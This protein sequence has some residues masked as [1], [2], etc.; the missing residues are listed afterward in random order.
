MIKIGLKPF[1]FSGQYFTLRNYLNK[2]NSCQNFLS[3]LLVE[4][5]QAANC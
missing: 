2:E 4:S 1:S 3:V 5:Q